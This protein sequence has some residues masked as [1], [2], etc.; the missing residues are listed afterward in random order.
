MIQYGYSLA[1]KSH[2]ARNKGCDDSHRIIELENGWIA[3]A[4]ADGVG[5]AANSA[6]G[7]KIA[8]DTVTD[9]CAEYLP[10]DES[11]IGIKSMLRTAFNHAYKQIL[12]KAKEEGN[13]V[14]S[15]DTTLSA[16][17]YDGHH[18][19]YGHSGDGAILGLTGEGKYVVLTTEQKGAD[20]ISVIPLRAGYTSWVIDR[21]DEELSSVLLVT[22]GMLEILCPSLLKGLEDEEGKV[23]VPLAS[24]FADPAAFEGEN[25]AERQRLR[26]EA[27]LKA[28]EDYPA[29]DFYEGLKNVY[30]TRVPEKSE[31]LLEELK[32][33]HYPVAFMQKV[34]DDKTA[35]AIIN[36]ESETQSREKAYYA[37]PDWRTLQLLWNKKAYPHLDWENED[38]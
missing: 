7:S 19:I 5:S 17:I 2:L 35:A 4:V 28:E 26:I 30:Q 22:D 29:E 11:V 27:F 32:K 13:P 21:Y 23:Y 33:H 3:A 38:E 9:F 16:V 14:E 10:W 6:V 24:F 12:R 36:T 8:V 18:V 15:Y 34:R 20:G 31:E 1:G 25:N 37:E